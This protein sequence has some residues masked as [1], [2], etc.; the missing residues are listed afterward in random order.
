ML[1]AKGGDRRAGPKEKPQSEP[2]RPTRP[3]PEEYLD[4]VQESWDPREGTT[5]EA[6]DEEQTVAPGT[7]RDPT[8]QEADG[9]PET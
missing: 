4:Q 7:T 9:T 1:G 5:R 3:E 8:N 2:E 6:D